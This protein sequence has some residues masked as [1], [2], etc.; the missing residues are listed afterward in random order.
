MTPKVQ[1]HAG[2]P[3]H[4]VPPGP[5]PSVSWSFWAPRW[6]RNMSCEAGW[7][8]SR[9]FPRRHACCSSGNCCRGGFLPHLIT[10]PTP[11]SP[12]PHGDLNAPGWSWES[13]LHTLNKMCRLRVEGLFSITIWNILAFFPEF[14]IAL[15]KGLPPWNQREMNWEVWTSDSPVSE[16]LCS[17]ES[18]NTGPAPGPGYKESVTYR[19]CPGLCATLR[20]LQGLTC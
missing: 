10:A 9:I 19:A 20:D 5:R 3:L 7:R 4:S 1:V 13:I 17:R 15:G 16:S 14:I 8:S 6:G 11:L 12:G 2:I 18:W